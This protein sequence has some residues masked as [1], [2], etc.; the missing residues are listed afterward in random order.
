MLSQSPSGYKLPY[1][2][3]RVGDTNMNANRHPALFYVQFKVVYVLDITNIQV[4]T[5]LPESGMHIIHRI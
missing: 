5:A 3:I 4:Q 2:D 1:N